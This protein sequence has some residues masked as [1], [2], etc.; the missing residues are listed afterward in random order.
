[1]KKTT[2]NVKVR[3]FSQILRGLRKNK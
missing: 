2:Q 3:E 1:L